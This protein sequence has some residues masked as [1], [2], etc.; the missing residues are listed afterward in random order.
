[1]N[2][3]S[4]FNS[5]RLNA[6]LL[7]IS[8]AFSGMCL[9]NIA[10]EKITFRLN[11][12]SITIEN[13]NSHL[14]WSLP[15]SSPFIQ[16]Y[17]PLPFSLRRYIERANFLEF[18]S[19]L[20]SWREDEDL[21]YF[22]ETPE[23]YH[24]LQSY[25]R[26]DAYLEW[27]R[28]PFRFRQYYM[29][30]NE[31]LTLSAERLD[32]DKHS[33]IYYKQ[34]R[35]LDPNE[36]LLGE[37]YYDSVYRIEYWKDKE[38]WAIELP[39]EEGG[40]DIYYPERGQAMREVKKSRAK[41]TY[42]QTGTYLYNEPPHFAS[43]R[44][45]KIIEKI[46]EQELGADTQQKLKA[47]FLGGLALSGG[48]VDGLRNSSLTTIQTPSAHTEEYTTPSS[49]TF[50]MSSSVLHY[51]TFVSAFLPLQPRFM[52]AKLMPFTISLL[53]PWQMA[54][55]QGFNPPIGPFTVNQVLQSGAAVATPTHSI[56]HK[57]GF[58]DNS[59]G[60][61]I[62]KK[63]TQEFN[64]NVDQVFSAVKN[65]FVSTD[66]S[67][68]GAL[69]EK[70]IEQLRFYN[71][72]AEEIAKFALPTEA[73]IFTKL[74]ESNK[75]NLKFLQKINL[76]DASTLSRTVE[77]FRDVPYERDTYQLKELRLEDRHDAI[78]NDHVINFC[79]VH[80]R[81]F[82][83]ILHSINLY[84]EYH[85]LL[86]STSMD[87]SLEILEIQ[88]KISILNDI[89]EKGRGFYLKTILGFLEDPA[90]A[91]LKTHVENIFYTNKSFLIH[92]KLHNF[93]KNL[94][95]KSYTV[96]YQNGSLSLSEFTLDNTPLPTI[97]LRSNDIFG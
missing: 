27:E 34:Q 91:S 14:S 54:Y 2:K 56:T 47:L 12:A 82:D 10:D 92:Y 36:H 15:T 49:W 80:E 69:F 26:G 72:Y 89:Y 38:F 48:I 63:A 24:T 25:K 94:D 28:G 8:S 77:S 93:P 9:E 87:A 3:S 35:Y 75:E 90:Y 62:C 68:Q 65:Y 73:D 7:S 33:K 61:K 57:V 88:S 58:P 44:V 23:F 18:E 20:P 83:L 79:K 66:F 39:Q 45:R 32:K 29:Q 11:P 4:S 19:F 16:T 67:E 40:L 22:V 13:P 70:I 6:F 74:H 76:A 96:R 1:M 55:A 50:N 81:A 59:K 71:I 30:P 17:C 95:L 5:F 84:R 21:S 97:F 52:A 31:L 37:V 64:I 41:N 42:K 78:I 60:S 85:D 86:M 46:E 43:P 53:G 51:A